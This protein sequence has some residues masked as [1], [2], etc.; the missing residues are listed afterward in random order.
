M[1]FCGKNVLVT[2]GACRVGREI[3]SYFAARGA[4]VVI[5]CRTHAAEAAALAASLPGSGH[6]FFACDLADSGSAAAIMDFCGRTDI[7]IN[8]ASLYFHDPSDAVSADREIMQVNYHTPAKLME[9]FAAGD[10]AEGCVVNILDQEIFAAE[11][12]RGAYSL[13]RRKLADLTRK[14]ALQY[15]HQNLRFNAVAP[16]PMIPPVGMENSGMV[17]TLPTLPLRRKV[18]ISDLCDAIG[19]LAAADSI[20]GAILPVDCGQSLPGMSEKFSFCKTE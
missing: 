11:I 16:G 9:L 6:R 3:V 18:A 5:H 13:S 10:I 20:T 12:T 4:Q 14:F 1:D 8:N 19:M 15:G 7:I 2:G 17:K